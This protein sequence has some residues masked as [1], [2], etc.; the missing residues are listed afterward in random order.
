LIRK[1]RATKKL[2]CNFEKVTAP[3]E[4]LKGNEKKKQKPKIRVRST[5]PA[6]KSTYLGR[7]RT[8]A[9]ARI[10]VEPIEPCM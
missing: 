4:K 10:P 6:I 1:A 8:N 9:C 5:N 3:V 2:K 7:G